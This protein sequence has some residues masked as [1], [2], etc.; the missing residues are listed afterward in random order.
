MLEEFPKTQACAR[1]IMPRGELSLIY[2]DG[3]FS[4]AV[5]KRAAQGEWRVQDELG[6]TVEAALTLLATDRTPPTKAA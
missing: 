5:V 3:G 1:L 4:H 6:G 2:L